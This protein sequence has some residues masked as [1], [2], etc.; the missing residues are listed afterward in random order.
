MIIL[1]SQQI[2]LIVNDSS[3]STLANSILLRI[4]WFCMTYIERLRIRHL[5]AK[6]RTSFSSYCTTL[7]YIYKVLVNI[8]SRTVILPCWSQVGFRTSLKTV[9][10][11]S[12][13]NITSSDI[14]II[15]RRARN[16]TL[17]FL[18]CTSSVHFMQCLRSSAHA[19]DIY[20]DLSLSLYTK[21]KVYAAVSFLLACFTFFMIW[22]AHV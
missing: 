3:I 10:L 19:A 17:D 8:S 11:H 1:L 4:T 5:V 9:N 6:S 15:A 7:R 16:F 20:L 21:Y 2:G 13:F 22:F 18:Q 12:T 14:V